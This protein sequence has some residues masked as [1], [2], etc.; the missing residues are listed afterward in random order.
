MYSLSLQFM[1]VDYKA[2]QL[3]PTPLQYNPRAVLAGTLY[4]SILLCL[5]SVSGARINSLM[6]VLV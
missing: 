2:L 5:V 1:K 3:C 6:R 4:N